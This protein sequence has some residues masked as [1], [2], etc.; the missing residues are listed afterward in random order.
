MRI[1]L[2]SPFFSQ[3]WDAGHFWARA[4]SSLGHTL[5]FWD[6]RHDPGM[7]AGFLPPGRRQPSFDVAVVMKGDL[8]ALTAARAFCAKALCYW[9]DALGRAP[10]EEKLLEG[11]HRVYT[12]VRPTPEGMV[13]LPGAWDDLVHSRHKK[14]YGDG[15]GV[16]FVGTRTPR[17]EHYILQMA[18]N[19]SMRMYGNGWHSSIHPVYL[20]EYV[21]ALNSADVALNIHRD[22]VGLNRRFF[23]MMAVNFTVTD[24][25]PGVREVLGDSLADR[26]SFNTPHEGAGMLRHFTTRPEER[27][28]LHAQELEAISEYSYRHLAQ[29]MLAD[30]A[31]LP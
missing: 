1:L 13:W 14:P 31:G 6:Y 20:H 5:C 22:F 30:L 15:G 11:Y 27:A 18:E 21:N 7:L 4:F 17:K 10:R 8:N 26:V 9:P 28:A 29:R 2:A 24:D 16:V 3:H 19:Q 23:E 25:V 12:P